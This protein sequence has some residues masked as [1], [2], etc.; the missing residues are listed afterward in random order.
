MYLRPA[1]LF[2]DI[3]MAVQKHFSLVKGKRRRDSSVSTGFGSRQS[4]KIFLYFTASRP[5][6]GRT[7]PP[8]IQWVPGAPYSDGLRAGRPGFDS[9]QCTIFLFSTVSRPVLAPTQ[10]PIQRVSAALSPWVKWQGRE[11]DHSPPS[12]VYVKKGELHLHAPKSSPHSA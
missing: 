8:I 2:A 6:R 3:V 9:R 1:K 10:P 5:A 12:S 11:A 7:P 4:Q